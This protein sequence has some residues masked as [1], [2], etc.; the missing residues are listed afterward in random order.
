MNKFVSDFALALG[1]V[2]LAVIFPLTA[3]IAQQGGPGPGT[4]TCTIHHS[5]C[6]PWEI[7]CIHKAINGTPACE[8]NFPVQ[9]LCCYS[10]NLESC[11]CCDSCP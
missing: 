1:V 5:S 8:V 4:P 7:G 11:A 9:P 6:Q 2:C 10:H 3:A